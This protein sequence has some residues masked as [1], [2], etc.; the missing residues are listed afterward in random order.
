MKYATL[1][2]F[3]RYLGTD[4]TTDD[5]LLL[6]L[7]EWSSRWID[8]YKG[9]SFDL[10]KKTM[11]YKPPLQVDT[12]PRIIDPTIMVGLTRPFPLRVKEDL[13]EVISLTSGGSAIEGYSLEPL[14]EYPK[15]RIYFAGS[16]STGNIC[17]VNTNL[18]TENISVEGWWG[19]N[20]DYPDCLVNS[21]DT[22]LE[23]ISDTET[24]IL[25]TNINGTPADLQTPRFQAGQLIKVEDELM[26]IASTSIDALYEDV[27]TLNVIRGYNGTTA[28][29]H[30]ATTPIY[31]YRV[32]TAIVTA[33]IRMTKWRYSQK[34][35]D[36]YDSTH[37]LGSGVISIP[38]AIPADILMILGAK[39]GGL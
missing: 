13:L 39:N 23:D 31:I 22:V 32:M 11:M 25:V 9:R 16:Y 27:H 17:D 30:V 24:A 15:N 6:D 19:Y 37:I 33:C 21:L 14:N 35:V 8:N 3:K 5:L 26:L 2:E 18:P 4:E 12:Y 28:V 20:K 38:S 1:I 34:D 7:L 29:A 10:K 36:S